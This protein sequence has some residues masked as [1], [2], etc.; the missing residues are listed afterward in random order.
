MRLAALAVAA[1]ILA[2]TLAVPACGGP[3]R[4]VAIVDGCAGAWRCVVDA[5]GPRDCVCVEKR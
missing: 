1:V 5:E 3:R 4:P 2:F